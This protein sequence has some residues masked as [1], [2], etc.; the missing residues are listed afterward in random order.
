MRWFAL[1]GKEVFPQKWCPFKHRVPAVILLKIEVAELIHIILGVLQYSKRG[2]NS[3]DNQTKLW[4]IFDLLFESQISPL[5]LANSILY[6]GNNEAVILAKTNWTVPYEQLY[7]SC[8]PN[9]SRR[10]V[11]SFHLIPGLISLGSTS[12]LS[13]LYFRFGKW[14][15]ILQTQA[16][17]TSSKWKTSIFW[18]IPSEKQNPLGKSSAF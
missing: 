10:L 4:K 16:S 18:C 3:K 6:V 11:L 2:S 7:Q 5:F 14:D 15:K 9:R 8:F 13:I 17:R 12:T 1:Q